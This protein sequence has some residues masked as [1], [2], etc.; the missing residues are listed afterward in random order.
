MERSRTGDVREFFL[1]A[2]HVMRRGR[3]G[4]SLN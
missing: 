1:R 4:F 2:G 3:Q